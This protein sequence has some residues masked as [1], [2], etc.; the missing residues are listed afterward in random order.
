MEEPICGWIE[1]TLWK[2]ISLSFSSTDTHFMALGGES[3]SG[4]VYYGDH[5]LCSE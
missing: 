2:M 1:R 5:F 4:P 3:V